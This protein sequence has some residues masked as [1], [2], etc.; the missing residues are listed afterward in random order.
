MSNLPISSYYYTTC[1]ET[2]D[3]ELDSEGIVNNANYLHYLE[4]TRHCFCRAEGISFT[5]MG[6]RGIVPVLRRVNIEYIKSLGGGE[7]I[8]SALNIHRDGARF[9]FDQAIFDSSGDICA[10]A[11]VSVVCIEN[12]RL[13]RGDTLASCFANAIA[14]S[15]K[16]SRIK[17]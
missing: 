16:I 15:D 10:K 17:H 5:E 12:G 3:Y 13:S 9:V 6:K 2:R 14:E 8:I 11:E 1:F 7:K 4:Y